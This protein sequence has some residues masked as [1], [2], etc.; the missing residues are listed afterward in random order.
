MIYL[1]AV[2]LIN[3]G[4]N[5]AC[6]DQQPPT[7]ETK[8]LQSLCIPFANCC[9]VNHLDESWLVLSF[10]LLLTSILLIKE[11]S[12]NFTVLYFKWMNV[13]DGSS[14]AVSVSLILAFDLLGFSGN[15]SVV[16]DCTCWGRVWIYSLRCFLDLGYHVVMDEPVNLHPEPTIL[17]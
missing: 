7:K 3:M 15:H 13:A 16:T 6:S 5:F 2:P 14:S 9:F 12:D 8:V 11:F 17:L 1:A 10:L 4:S